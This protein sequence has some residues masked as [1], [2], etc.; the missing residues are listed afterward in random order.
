VAA[1]ATPLLASRLHYRALEPV[2]PK[3]LSER[4][5]RSVGKESTTSPL[6]VPELGEKIAFLEGQG[7]RIVD[8]REQDSRLIE[9]FHFTESLVA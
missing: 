2:D 8:K 6:Q 9:A 5:S 7:L 4:F 3:G 1:F